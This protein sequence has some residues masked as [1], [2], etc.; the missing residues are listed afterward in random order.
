MPRTLPILLAVI[1][2]GCLGHP[3]TA[4]APSTFHS[5]RS[6]RDATRSAAVALVDAGFRVTQSDSLGYSLN[7]SRTA[8]HNG[9]SEF[10]TCQMPSGSA[11]AANRETTLT[12]AFQATPAT[13]GSDITVSSS[14]KTD[15]PGYEGTAIQVPMGDSLCVSSGTM[16]RRLQAALR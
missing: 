5:A 14:V 15:Y 6:A 3:L 12:I 7:A 9:N 4:P 8:S 10:V 2:T 13:A 11:A 16:E 1:A